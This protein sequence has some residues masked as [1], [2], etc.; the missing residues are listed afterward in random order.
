MTTIV[1]TGDGTQLAVQ[2]WGQGRPVVLC[3]AWAMSSRMWDAQVPALVDA[4]FRCVTFDRRGHGRSDVP[5][6]GYDLNTFADDLAAIVDTLDLHDVVLVGHSAGAQEVVR[7]LSRCGADRVSGVV[8]SAPVTP[9]ILKRDDFPFGI[10]E[11]IFEAQRAAWRNDFGAWVDA[12][13][14]AY[15]GTATVSNALQDA[16]K[17]MLLDTPLQVVLETNKVLTRADLRTDLLALATLD[18]RVTVVQGT[19]D[20]SA[21]IAATARPTAAMLAGSTLIEIEGAG[22]GLY[23]GHAK[24]YNSALLTACGA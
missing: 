10:D 8:L 24:E 22:H 20:A 21:P 19:L 18:I 16:T 7:Y 9:C 17:R 1:T 4:G 5:S 2:D 13:S 12:N 11:A 15:F 6:G 14:A 23:L 3:H